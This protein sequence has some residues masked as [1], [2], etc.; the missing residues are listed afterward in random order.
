MFP[1]STRVDLCEESALDGRK[2]AK[3][4]TAICFSQDPE[5]ARH[6]QYHSFVKLL[7]DF[8][9]DCTKADAEKKPRPHL[10]PDGT[11]SYKEYA[12]WLN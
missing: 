1:G 11:K 3:Y 7:E 10:N 2:M 8:T 12:E 9:I 6:A 4:D 5:D